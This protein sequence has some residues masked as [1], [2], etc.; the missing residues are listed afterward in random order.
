MSPAGVMRHSHASMSGM[1]ERLRLMADY[2]S[3]PLWRDDGD[4]V[5]PA[6]LPISE[7]LQARLTAWA[8]RF[9]ETLDDADPLMSGF[10]DDAA[11]QAFDADGH[12][13]WAAL[14]RELGEAW[15]VAYFTP[16][17]KRLLEAPTE[18]EDRTP[19]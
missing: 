18:H 9:D 3:W 8:A 2:R 14:R 7:A 15:N 19:D 13:L 6:T 12:H 1:G 10:F 17:E 4:N 16:R 5:D 11:E